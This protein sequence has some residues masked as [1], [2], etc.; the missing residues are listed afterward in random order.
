VSEL[1]SNDVEEEVYSSLND[2]PPSLKRQRFV[3]SRGNIEKAKYV[4]FQLSGQTRGTSIL[5]QTKPLLAVHKISAI[6]LKYSTFDGGFSCFH[7][8]KVQN[9]LHIVAFAL[10]SLLTLQLKKVNFHLK[11]NFFGLQIG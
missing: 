1:T 6:L 2:D 3:P 4:S 8:E 9:F 11:M 7:G 5:G 10:K